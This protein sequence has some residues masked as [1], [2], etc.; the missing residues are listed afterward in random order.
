MTPSSRISLVALVLLAAP[1]VCRGGDQSQTDAAAAQSVSGSIGQSLNAVAGSVAAGNVAGIYG[2]QQPGDPGTALA[3]APRG[4]GATT[5]VV[6]NRPRAQV[7]LSFRGDL[8]TPPPPDIAAPVDSGRSP[9]FFSGLAAFFSG[10]PT[11]PPAQP[12]ANP[13]FG[14]PQCGPGQSPPCPM[15][16]M[17]MN[18][19]TPFKAPITDFVQYGEIDG[20]V[21]RSPPWWQFWKNRE[22][23][24]GDDIHQGAVGDCF[25]LAALAAIAEKEPDFLR[26]MFKQ[27]KNSKSLFVQ[28]YDGSPLKPVFVGPVDNQFP[29]YKNGVH[30]GG[31]DVSGRS[32]F[33]EPVDGKSPIWPLIIEKAYTVKFRDDSYAKLDWG[34]FSSDAME[35]VTGRPSLK[36]VID[37]KDSEYKSDVTFDQLVQWDSRND[38]IVMGTKSPPVGGCALPAPA[39][40]SAPAPAAPAPTPAG[41]AT[42]AA[43]AA[44]EPGAIA[45]R[46]MG[47]G[48][49]PDA[50]AGAGSA[51]GASDTDTICEDPL[52]QGKIACANRPDDPVCAHAK[53]IVKLETS[54]AYWVKKIDSS[55]Q[56]VTL[57]N[58]WGSDQ[59]TI[60]LPWSRFHRS[61]RR[62]YVNEN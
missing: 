45:R 58:P 29:V 27:N 60:T 13:T 56:T 41:G 4:S 24:D 55:D 42:G 33:A 3:G 25:L 31:R 16:V 49:E 32:A 2:E 52:Y 40:P 47:A 62:V 18:E 38:P 39:A 26:R 15:V 19:N 43:G 46:K 10:A 30:A 50:A 54:H 6:D 59:P 21:F 36:L 48:G 61:L 11:T 53:K 35:H 20:K 8:L 44:E 14:Y 5:N 12:V 57:A 37:P 9:G 51:N 7:P 22:Q 28:F 1:R 17:S 23:A 34:G